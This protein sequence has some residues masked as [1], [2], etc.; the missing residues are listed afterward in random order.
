MLSIKPNSNNNNDN[1]PLSVA[2]DN[3]CILPMLLGSNIVD[4][5]EVYP[6]LSIYNFRNT[7]AKPKGI[8]VQHVQITKTS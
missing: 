1:D 7:Q 4:R 5:G 2:S 8:I 3:D 6:I